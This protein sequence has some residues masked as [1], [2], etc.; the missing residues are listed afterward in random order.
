MPRPAAAALLLAVAAAALAAA[1]A[2]A[3]SSLEVLATQYADEMPACG[4]RL[5]PP[6]D[7]LLALFVACWNPIH[8]STDAPPAAC[9]SAECETYTAALGGACWA[10]AMRAF[11]EPY[12]VAAAALAGGPAMP[13]DAVARLQAVNDARTASKN[14]QPDLAAELAAGNNATLAAK[15]ANTGAHARAM[16]AACAPPEAAPAP[17]PAAPAAAPPKLAA[18]PAAKPK[19]PRCTKALHKKKVACRKPEKG[20]GGKGRGK[21]K[22]H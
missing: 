11:G 22:K 18:K 3:A 16:A 8:T 12:L 2:R 20:A 6:S 21:G 19:L 9:P 4:A 5:T 13:A 15:F 7:E 1:P 14:P 17:S 10:Q